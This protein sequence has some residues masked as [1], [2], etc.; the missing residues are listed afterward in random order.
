MKCKPYSEITVESRTH[1]KTVKITSNIFAVQLRIEEVRNV[2]YFGL[3]FTKYFICLYFF[4][5]S[6]MKDGY[7]LPID[8]FKVLQSFQKLE[9]NRSKLIGLD[10]WKYSPMWPHFDLS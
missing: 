1:L 9:K 6:F 3:F 4:F 8:W 7:N 10:L 2:V 5:T